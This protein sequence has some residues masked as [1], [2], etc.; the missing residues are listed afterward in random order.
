MNFFEDDLVCVES[1]LDCMTYRDEQ[2]VARFPSQK[3]DQI[4][5]SIYSIRENANRFVDEWSVRV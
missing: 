4:S 5:N 1:W 3:V 2:E